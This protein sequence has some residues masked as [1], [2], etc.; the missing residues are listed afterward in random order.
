MARRQ[1][2]LTA[3]DLKVLTFKQ[4]CSLNGISITTGKRLFAAGDGPAV[5]QLSPR[6][7]GIRMIDNARWLEARTR[8]Q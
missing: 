4:W 7:K 6:R 8:D 3:D 2:H 5:V 1:E